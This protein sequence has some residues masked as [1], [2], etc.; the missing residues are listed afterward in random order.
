MRDFNTVLTALLPLKKTSDGVCCSNEK[1]LQ[2]SGFK[3]FDKIEDVLYNL[4]I[5]TNQTSP[6]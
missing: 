3:T 1:F 4:G 2:K 6:I 5:N